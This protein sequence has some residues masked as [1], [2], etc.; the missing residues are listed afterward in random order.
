MKPILVFLLVV[1]L[2]QTSALAQSKSPDPVQPAGLEGVDDHGV[3]RSLDFDRLLE[4]PG[5]RWSMPR[6]AA[7]AVN[8]VH[9]V[10]AADDRVEQAVATT[11]QVKAAAIPRINL[12]GRYTRLSQ[13]NNVPLVPLDI[14]FEAAEATLAEVQDPAAQELLG[15]NLQVLEAI[16]SDSIPVPR[17]RYNF[18]AAVSYPVLQL[19]L[20][21]LPG[22]RSAEHGE[23][24]ERFQ[25]NVVRNDVALEVI[26][27]Y[28][29]HARAR[30]A[31]AVAELAVRQAEENRAQAEAL[32]RGG[33][34]NRP[35]V[36]RFEARVAAAQRARAESLAQV[37]STANAL[38]TLLDIPGEG[39]LAFQER[40]NEVPEPSVTEGRED[41]I[42]AAWK[43]R[44]ELQAA[45]AA[46]KSRE[47]AVRV[48]RGAMA[49]TLGVEAG[50]DYARPNPLFIPPI[51][52]FRTSWNVSAVANWSPDG[53]YTASR[54]KRRALA[55]LNEVEEQR[56]QLRDLVRIE[57]V[58]AHAAYEASFESVRAAKRQVEA[59]E[60]A[61]DAKRRGFEVGVFDA[62]E[63]IDAEVDANR[64]RLAL[65]DAAARLRIRESTLRTA[66]GEHLWE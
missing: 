51:D 63:V 61:Y 21:I 34:G 40:F 35:D 49:P 13:I 53:T 10:N 30:G 60:E 45:N 15:A 42:D 7:R 25:A 47:Y 66:I 22:I 28:M 59:A 23:T 29:N 64:A 1:F 8:T 32:L 58:R 6:I 54:A 46:V 2:P 57:V 36:L 41:L 43:L 19:F 50:A 9:L 17:N 16:S 48:S 31:H 4:E 52:D 33:V 14:D 11:Q 24:A 37:D 65:I 20:Q 62:T 18:R 56:Q 3:P 38:R 26:E 55:E 5:Q 12:R 27:I 39:P 44:D